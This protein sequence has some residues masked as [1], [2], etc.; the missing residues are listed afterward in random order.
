MKSEGLP[1]GWDA[2]DRGVFMHSLQVLS[3]CEGANYSPTR[4]IELAVLESKKW[5]ID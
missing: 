5:E 1:G 2:S 4:M 3:S